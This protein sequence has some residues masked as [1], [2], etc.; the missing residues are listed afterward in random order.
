MNTV[1]NFEAL[2][3]IASVCHR[4]RGPGGPPEW[5]LAKAAAFFAQFRAGSI[6]YQGCE[7]FS[8]ERL[9]SRGLLLDG[10]VK[11]TLN[12]L[13]AL[14]LELLEIVSDFFPL[15]TKILLLP[16]DQLSLQAV[17]WSL[18]LHTAPTQP[19]YNRRRPLTGSLRCLWSFL[20]MSSAFSVQNQCFTAVKSILASRHTWNL[21]LPIVPTKPAYG[22]SRDS[23][24]I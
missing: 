10:L 17:A 23:A 21:C 11:H 2:V 15:Y 6:R 22:I 7:G 20:N 16:S 8:V 3:L 5:S 4:H 9:S 1:N 24:I 13:F 19:I 18:C 12:R 14:S